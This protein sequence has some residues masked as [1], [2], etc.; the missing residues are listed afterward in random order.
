M[1]RLVGTSKRQIVKQG[2]KK[3]ERERREQR[4]KQIV[5]VS[6]RQGRDARQGESE[7]PRKCEGKNK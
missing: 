3:R 1:R 5:R 7:I 4:L 2:E 6:T